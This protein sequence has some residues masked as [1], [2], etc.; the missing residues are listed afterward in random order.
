MRRYSRPVAIEHDISC[1]PTLH[2]Q[3]RQKQCEEA[4]ARAQELW[5]T[6]GAPAFN[7]ETAL[8][9]T[10]QMTHTRAAPP[11]RVRTEPSTRRLV[12][13]WD[14]QEEYHIGART[15]NCRCTPDTKR[16]VYSARVESELKEVRGKLR[17]AESELQEYKN[18]D[19]EEVRGTIE[20]IRRSLATQ[21]EL[22]QDIFSGV[23]TRVRPHPHRERFRRAHLTLA[24][25]TSSRTSQSATSTPSRMAALMGLR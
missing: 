5:T 4:L 10:A 9:Y 24:C 23:K 20:T 14:F 25:V 11:I 2:I 19:V 22:Q 18:L 7:P 13:G 12:G 16:P 17:R 21:S 15:S 3:R 8:Q 6:Y 1:S